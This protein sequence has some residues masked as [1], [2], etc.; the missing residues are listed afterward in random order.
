MPSVDI[1]LAC[2]MFVVA[3]SDSM[4]ALLGCRDIAGRERE[5]SLSAVTLPSAC[6]IV[7]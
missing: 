4:D 3:R 2:A 7:D 6:T 1:V 5:P